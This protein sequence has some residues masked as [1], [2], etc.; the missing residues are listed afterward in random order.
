MQLRSSFIQYIET[1]APSKVTSTTNKVHVY[2]A[3]F[4]FVNISKTKRFVK[5][6][7]FLNLTVY[8]YC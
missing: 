1:K 4:F 7:L 2:Q 5:I 3:R 6:K 8:N